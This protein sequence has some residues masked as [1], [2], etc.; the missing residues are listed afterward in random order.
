MSAPLGGPPDREPSTAG[1][2]ARRGAPWT[3]RNE[4]LLGRGA[5]LLVAS[6]ILAVLLAGM[7]GG[8]RSRTVVGWLEQ[9][10]FWLGMICIAGEVLREVLGK[11]RP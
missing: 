2:A 6:F 3:F 8:D 9:A 10:A 4:S 11:R 7:D 1:P 5:V